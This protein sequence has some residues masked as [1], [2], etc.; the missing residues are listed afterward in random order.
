MLRDSP[1][2]AV[3]QAQWQAMEAA[4][5]AGRTRSVGVINYCEASLRCE[6]CEFHLMATDEH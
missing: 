1:D 4:L 3:M 6:A 5:A 2:C